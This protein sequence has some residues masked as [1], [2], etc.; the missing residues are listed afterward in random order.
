[1]GSRIFP[2]DLSEALE[3]LLRARWGDQY[4]N[5]C[6]GVSKH[7]QKPP[8]SLASVRLGEEKS[9]RSVF[10]SHLPVSLCD[11]KENPS[12]DHGGDSDHPQAAGNTKFQGH[13]PPQPIQ[14]AVNKHTINRV[15]YKTHFLKN[16]QESQ[17]L[18]LTVWRVE[19]QGPGGGL[20]PGH[21]GH[22]P[23]WWKG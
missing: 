11:V 15:A 12:P 3:D 10:C 7:L 1:M 22:L 19:G 14:A 16:K 20:L 8:R 17:D 18:S 5:S 4:P 21:R 23:R 13:P 2:R 6:D 9:S